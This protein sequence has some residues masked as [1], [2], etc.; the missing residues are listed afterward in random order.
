MKVSV[1]IPVYNQAHYLGS[2]IQSV[3][4]QTWGDFEVVVVD[5]G[6]TD[7]TRQVV[8]AVSDARVHYIY[9]GNKGPSGARNTGIRASSG[10]YVAFL[11]ADDL[12]LPDKLDSQVT[13]LDEN[14]AIGLVA[15]GYF[16][17]NHEGAI[18][19]EQRPWL[20]FPSLTFKHWILG[21]A[22]VPTVILVRR[23]WLEQVGLFDERL[24]TDE[25][26][27]L[28]LRL[29]HAGCEMRWLERPVCKY[30]IHASN[31]TKNP[32]TMKSGGLAVLDKLFAD[33]TLPD[34]VRDL[35]SR[36][37]S[38]VFLEAACRGYAGGFVQ[39]AQMDL[40]QAIKLAPGLLD[41]H[42]PRAL[43]TFA[44]W[45]LTPHVRDPTVFLD[46]LLS[47]LPDNAA[48]L[49]WSRRK[50]RGLLR[51]VAAFEHYQ[52]QEYKSTVIEAI[53]AW[54]L[55][56]RWLGNRGLFSITGRAIWKQAKSLARK[57]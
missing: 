20:S 44:S 43:S 12:F 33:P 5:D 23:M 24:R 30:R 41:G 19:R 16:Y 25:D 10:E 11:D 28:Y 2:A 49:R 52:R 3:L 4:E 35:Q 51:A 9:Q 7:H 46:T 18:L 15:G 53:S 6:S 48:A 31:A 26:W 32:A 36:A 54:A 40:Q 8:E 55:D 1:I 29:A 38:K 47:N 57:R 27:D 50:A 56:P 14:P 37:Q 39:E 21:Q 22:F 42:P 34:T 45:A 17:I 13:F